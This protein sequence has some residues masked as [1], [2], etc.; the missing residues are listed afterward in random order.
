[1]P[2]T[3]LTLRSLSALHR[4]AGADVYRFGLWE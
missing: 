4:P 2:S 1:M 3:S